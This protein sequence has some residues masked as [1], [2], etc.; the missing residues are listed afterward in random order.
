M[1]MCIILSGDRLLEDKL[2]LTSLAFGIEERPGIIVIV[3]S[4]SN[5]EVQI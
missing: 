1:T 2:Y 5:F 3:S 4:V